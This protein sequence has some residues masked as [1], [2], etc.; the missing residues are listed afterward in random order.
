M[1]MNKMAA[2]L[3]ERINTVELQRNEAE[4]GTVEY[5]RERISCRYE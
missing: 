3:D 2:E 1:A 4:G 5:D